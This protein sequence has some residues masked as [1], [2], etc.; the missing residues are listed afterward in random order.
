MAPDRTLHVL[1]AL[2]IRLL[3]FRFRRKTRLVQLSDE[4][5][6]GESTCLTLIL[7]GGFERSLVGS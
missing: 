2:P 5:G 1:H 6:L 4:V 3:H 7:F